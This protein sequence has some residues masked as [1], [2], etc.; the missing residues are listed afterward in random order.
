MLDTSNMT[1]VMEKLE[2]LDDEALAVKLLSEFNEASSRLGVLVR[3]LDPS[4]DHIEWKKE[5]DRA[6]QEV[7][8]IVEKIMSL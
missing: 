7:K 4:L 3:N 5:C 6:S 2:G 1:K 8:S